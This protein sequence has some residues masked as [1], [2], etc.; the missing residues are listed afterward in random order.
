MVPVDPLMPRPLEIGARDGIELRI[1]GGRLRR[2]GV[3]EEVRRAGDEDARV[4][5]AAIVSGEADEAAEIARR[6]VAGF[7]AAVR[8]VI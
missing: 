8:A 3:E 1:E 6:H 7:E 5:A 4:R 2:V